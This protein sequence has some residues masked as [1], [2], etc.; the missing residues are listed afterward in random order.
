MILK[1]GSH[2]FPLPGSEPLKQISHVLDG[3]Q[4]IS[5]GKIKRIV[6]IPKSL[7]K[8]F[9]WL[10]RPYHK[11]AKPKDLLL[12]RNKSKGMVFP[13][14]LGLCRLSPVP[15]GKRPF[16][17]LSLQ[18]LY[19]CKDPHPAASLRCT[20][21]FLPKGLWSHLKIYK[22]RRANYPLQCN[23]NDGANFGVAVIP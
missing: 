11:G 5:K 13:C 12:V 18:S 4:T 23:F 21:Q 7:V 6:D 2:L 17:T 9:G 1:T 19:R 10:V 14:K 16:P 20:C 8:R 22:V 15:A 3:S